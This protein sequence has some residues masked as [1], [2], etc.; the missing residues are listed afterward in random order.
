LN[1]EF[2]QIQLL[3]NQFQLLLTKKPHGNI[4]MSD[5]VQPF[6]PSAPIKDLKLGN[7]TWDHQIENAHGD[8][9]L[10]AVPAVIELYDKGV[11]E[12]K[13]Q[14]AFSVGAFGLE[15]NC[16]GLCQQDGASLLL[17]IFFQRI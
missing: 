14:R 6:G 7:T 15:K 4:F 5:E 13:I 9:D 11:L 8:T 2:F 3:F 16:G 12:T 17:M 10:K 1:K